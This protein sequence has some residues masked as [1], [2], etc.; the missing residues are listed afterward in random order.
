MNGLRTEIQ[1]DSS[2]HL[3]CRDGRHSLSMCIIPD[4]FWQDRRSITTASSVQVLQHI[5]D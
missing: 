3:G 4:S 2:N 5:I 1:V